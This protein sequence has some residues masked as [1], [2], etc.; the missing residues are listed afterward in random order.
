MHFPSVK[1]KQEFA[2]EIQTLLEPRIW[3]KISSPIAGLGP[4]AKFDTFHP[5][6]SYLEYKQITTTV[7][8]DLKHFTPF[9][10]EISQL[11]LK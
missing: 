7:T 3:K 9:T 5:D 1:Y 10:T 4:T 11:Y 6:I 2:T 8:A